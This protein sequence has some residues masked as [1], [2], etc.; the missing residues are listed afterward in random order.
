MILLELHTGEE[1]KAGFPDTDSLYR[2]VE[3]AVTYSGL[4]PLGLM[5][6]APFTKDE[7][8][9]RAS[10]RKLREALEGLKKRFP[11]PGGWPCLSMG[12]SGDFELAVEEGSTLVR[13]GTA[14]FGE[15]G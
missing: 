5:T 15:R 13:I 8:T 14:I 7:K 11:H 9:L 10:F 3:K 4:N 1:S 12:M 6:M 2:A